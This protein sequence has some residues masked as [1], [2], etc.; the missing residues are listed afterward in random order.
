MDDEVPEIG[1]IW[2]YAYEPCPSHSTREWYDVWSYRVTAHREV[3]RE[4]RKLVVGAQLEPLEVVFVYPEGYVSIAGHLLPVPPK[5][6]ADICSPEQKSIR[7]AIDAGLPVTFKMTWPGPPPVP[8]PS[9][10]R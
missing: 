8:E 2:R 10:R 3:M 4:D 7:Q 5:S 6:I 1:S 9:L